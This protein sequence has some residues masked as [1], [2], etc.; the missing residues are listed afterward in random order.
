MAEASGLYS[1][2]NLSLPGIPPFQRVLPRLVSRTSIAVKALMGR[3]GVGSLRS[4]RLSPVPDDSPCELNVELLAGDK[5]SGVSG[6]P[7]STMT[8]CTRPLRPTSSAWN[9][10]CAA[11]SKPSLPGAF[12]SPRA[13]A[14]SQR[15]R[16]PPGEKARGVGFS[17]FRSGVGWKTGTFGPWV[18]YTTSGHSS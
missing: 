4:G 17:T 9:L 2:K 16:T 6:G 14:A 5:L 7:R 18:S 12:P 13:M 1:I 8:R 11:R 10:S 15:R 3:G